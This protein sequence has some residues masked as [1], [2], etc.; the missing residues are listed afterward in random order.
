MRK[1]CLLS[2]IMS[3]LF[4]VSC[5]PQDEASG[6]PSYSESGN[7]KLVSETAITSESSSF[8]IPG[9]D[10]TLYGIIPSGTSTRSTA[11]PDTGLTKTESGTY[12]Y[13]SDGSEKTFRG[14]DISIANGT[15]RIVEYIPSSGEMVIDTASDTPTPGTHD[16]FEKYY[17]ADLSGLED[18][19]SI[20]LTHTRD[21]ASGEFSYDYGIISGN[22][23]AMSNAIK[24]I[25]DL[26]ASDS[27]HIFH[28]VKRDEGDMKQ[29]LIFMAPQKLEF[30]EEPE[31]E[32]GIEISTPS[33][34]MIEETGKELVLEI[35]LKT[36]IE[37]Y[38]FYYMLPDAQTAEGGEHLPYFMP[39]SYDDKSHIVQLYLGSLSS[40]AVFSI[41]TGDE[42][43]GKAGEEVILRKI[44]ETEKAL[45][46]TPENNKITLRFDSD[47]WIVP[48]NFRE[49][50]DI[51]SIKSISGDFGSTD[52]RFRFVYSGDTGAAL[53][54]IDGNHNDFHI[55]DGHSL[56]YGFL[57]NEGKESGTVTLALNG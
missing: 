56:E 39:M 19:K 53:N 50:E 4:L 41:S 38:S 40:P 2:T 32:R 45:F 18:K 49:K 34:F 24:G 15:V 23:I 25:R 47:D 20:F 36:R 8:T 3:M 29:K 1:I 11:A 27:M 43:I 35:H 6:D 37:D 9:K 30:T 14:S 17:I 28:Q 16:I 42:E 55:K 54:T 44:T 51:G 52:T 22:E 57:I 26:S 7:A 48:V 21:R 5:A 12:L 13:L 10:G 46:K 33:A 31:K